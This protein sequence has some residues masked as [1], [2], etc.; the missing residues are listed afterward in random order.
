LDSA[1]SFGISLFGMR[2]MF[3]YC[4][5]KAVLLVLKGQCREILTFGFLHQSLPFD[6]LGGSLEG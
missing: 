2:C 3:S 1:G 4:T 5:I 6:P